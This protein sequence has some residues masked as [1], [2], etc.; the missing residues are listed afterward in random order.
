MARDFIL[1]LI[2]TRECVISKTIGRYEIEIRPA[3]VSRQNSKYFD[4]NRCFFLYMMGVNVWPV[5]ILVV[6]DD[7]NI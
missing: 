6:S 1:S 3:T 4:A 5:S 7:D 2:L